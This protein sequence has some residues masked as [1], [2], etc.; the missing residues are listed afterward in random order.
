MLEVMAVNLTK[1][2]GIASRRHFTEFVSSLGLKF[3]SVKQFYAPIRD[4]TAILGD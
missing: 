2:T 4:K 3:F 1:D